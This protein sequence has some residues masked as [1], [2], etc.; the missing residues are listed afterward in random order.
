M[1]IDIEAITVE[2]ATKVVETPEGQFADVKA[3]EI[4][5]AKLTKTLSAFSNSDGGDLYIGIG[6]DTRTKNREW[7]GFSRIEDANGHLQ[8]FEGLFPLGSEFQYEF[9]SCSNLPGFVLH[10]QINKTQSIKQASNGIPYVRRGAQNLSVENHE[11]LK[12]LEYCKGIS[13]FESETS[14]APLELVTQSEVITRFIQNVVPEAAPEKWLKKQMLIRNELPTVA[15]ILLF[16]DEPQAV[17]PK[18]CGIKIYRYKTSAAEG[19]RE[20]LAFDPKTIEGCAYDQ[21]TASVAT[22]VAI[23]ETIPKLGDASLEK[24]AYPGEALHEIITNAVIHRDY[25]VADDVHIRIFDNRVE[26]QSPGKLPAHITVQNILNERFARNGA[27]VRIL[28]KFPNPPNKDVGEGLNTAF[29]AMHKLGLKEPTIEEK[30]NCVLVVI[31]HEPLA[32]PEEA[33][34]DYLATHA[35]IKNAVARRLTHIT[36]DHQIKS[37]F[38]RMVKSGL[39]E[40]VP[41][42]RTSNTAYRKKSKEEPPPSAENSG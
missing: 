30:E 29:S 3:I 37:I 18:R 6:E 15:G 19:F 26:V 39:L 38:G 2:Q 20:A 7:R 28:N 34:M 12:R 25:S 22:T 11:A 21:I 36:A 5:P 13:S 9:L 23:T 4:Q 41:G 33:I 32:S 40:Q 16:S 14:S 17:L 8:A 1:P 35:T 24:I 10:A 31:K 27:V 42:T